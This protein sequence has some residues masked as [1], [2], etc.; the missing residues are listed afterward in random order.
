[1]TETCS[2]EVLQKLKNLTAP[3]DD[4]A[5]AGDAGKKTETIDLLDSSD[6][7]SDSDGSGE[8][9]SSGSDGCS[10]SD[11][12]KSV[13]SRGARSTRSHRSTKS[14]KSLKD[15]QEEE[16]KSI[17][18]LIEA[19]PEDIVLEA[20]QN[21]RQHPAYVAS[22]G[23]EDDDDYHAEK[24][25]LPMQEHCQNIQPAEPEEEIVGIAAARRAARGKVSARNTTTTTTTSKPSNAA[26]QQKQQQPP[27]PLPPLDIEAARKIVL[28]NVQSA[29][30]VLARWRLGV[31]LCH[32]ISKFTGLSRDRPELRLAAVY[33]AAASP[34][35][36]TP[37]QGS[38]KR[39]SSCDALLS[40]LCGSKPGGVASLS[41]DDLS[42]LVE[43]L[44]E[45]VNS[46][47]MVSHTIACISS[48]ACDHNINQI[49]LTFWAIYLLMLP[50]RIVDII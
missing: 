34:A 6:D 31:L 42:R 9:G 18:D 16:N 45:L 5:K 35:F 17:E 13:K 50:C 37:P 8:S 2:T 10:D 21:M 29:V 39:P 33:T 22:P 28:H 26:P 25:A 38:S 30:D 40:V 20:A 19:L 3:A 4:K 32:E 24:G 36:D 23:N 1:M 27:P 44:L 7:D 46:S 41:D 12:G 47:Q 11:D 15:K 49:H 48:S 43:D 14:H